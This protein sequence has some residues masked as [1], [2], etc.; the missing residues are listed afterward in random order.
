MNLT[1]PKLVAEGAVYHDDCYKKFI[2]LLSTEGSKRGRP[3]SDNTGTHKNLTKPRWSSFKTLKTIPLSVFR[4][5]VLRLSTEELI[6][7]CNQM[8]TS[9]RI[10]VVPF[11][12]IGKLV[13]QYS[14]V[15]PD[16]EKRTTALF[17]TSKIH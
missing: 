8:D 17:S 9:N 16:S 3:K 6:V 2:N 11:D 7:L 14:D 10:S 1:A 13:L 5:Q 4:Y 15:R 12:Y